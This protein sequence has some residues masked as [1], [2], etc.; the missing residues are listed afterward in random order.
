M[1]VDGYNPQY[2][3]SVKQAVDRGRLQAMIDQPLPATPAPAAWHVGNAQATASSS[4]PATTAAQAS[5]AAPAA[6]PA[7]TTATKAEPDPPQTDVAQKTK[8]TVNKLRG[9]LGH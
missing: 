1:N 9:L 3:E 6:S 4:A 7:T 5:D 8:D 2:M